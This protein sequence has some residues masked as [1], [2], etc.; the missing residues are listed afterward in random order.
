MY[1]LNSIKKFIRGYKPNVEEYSILDILC[2]LMKKYI[3]NENAKKIKLLF[4]DIIESNKT[5]R[6]KLQTNKQKTRKR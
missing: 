6:R 5:K 2:H 3:Y 1:N 4:I